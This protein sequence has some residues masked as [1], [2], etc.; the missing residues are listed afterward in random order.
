MIYKKILQTR[1]YHN[2]GKIFLAIAIAYGAYT[3]CTYYYSSLFKWIYSQIGTG[4]GD[5]SETS[6]FSLSF[7]HFF[8]W[9]NSLFIGLIMPF[10]IVLIS[11]ALHFAIRPSL[12]PALNPQTERRLLINIGIVF[13]FLFFI[14]EINDFYWIKLHDR[15]F[16]S[17]PFPLTGIPIHAI[18]FFIIVG[19]GMNFIM[20]TNKKH[21]YTSAS[22]YFIITSCLIIW[23]LASKNEW[24]TWNTI[25]LLIR[26]ATCYIGC[27][28]R[29]KGIYL[30]KIIFMYL[31]T[32]ISIYY[33]LS[34]VSLYFN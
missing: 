21:L 14:A 20:K 29:C 19:L 17:W 31:T 33:L 2:L 3:L 13:S 5:F 22:I 8:L 26:T 4:T 6:S 18:F 27:I 15:S 11:I 7:L 34:Y 1:F 28:L 16:S 24:N 9:H 25:P 23:S 30:Y 12:A 10:P 32:H